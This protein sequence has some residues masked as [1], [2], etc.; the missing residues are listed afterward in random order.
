MEIPDY[1]PGCMIPHMEIE[2]AFTP[3]IKA[4]WASPLQ[5]T[6]QI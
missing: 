2:P 4:G 5:A 6:Q 1:N 3:V